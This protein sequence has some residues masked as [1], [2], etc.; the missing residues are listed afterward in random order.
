M[1]KNSEV[2]N[3]STLLLKQATYHTNPIAVNLKHI[4]LKHTYAEE[5]VLR[6]FQSENKFMQKLSIM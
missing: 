5:L 4:L 6:H 1:T 2:P 3:I